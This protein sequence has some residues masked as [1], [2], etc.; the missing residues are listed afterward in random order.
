MSSMAE[1]GA[2][3]QARTG[4]ASWLRQAAIAVAVLA[5]AGCQSII[6][7]GQ[8]PTTEA[9][10]PPVEEEVVAGIPQ[11]ST[12]HRI[13]LLVP[14]SG[15]NAGVGQSIQ[16]ATTMALLD[17]QAENIRITAYDTA[18]GI[19]AA[20]NNAVQDGNKL[21][22]GPLL[23]DNVL[24]TANIAGRANIPMLSFSN[25]VSVARDNVFLLGHIPSQSIDRVVRYAES[26]GMQRFAALV[27]DNVYGQRALAAIRETTQATGARLVASQS[28]SRDSN[29]IDAA[30]KRL[31]KDGGDFDA[32]LIADSAELAIKAVPYV[33]RNGGTGKVLGTELWN[34]SG[35]LTG[36]PSMNGAWFASVSDGV[37]KQYADKYRARYGKA[38]FR[39]SSMGYDAV[40]LTVKIARDW[41]VGTPFPIQRLTDRDGFGGLDGVFRFMPNGVNER[42]LEV[43][44]VGRGSFTVIDPAPRGF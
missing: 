44:E 15:R 29:S 40:L 34:T 22:L 5:L 17:T 33:R 41:K 27:P 23:G 32:I 3:R 12:H 13:A 8:A 2:G 19:T 35:Q 9:P 4:A 42:A 37:Y 11:D 1:S 28:Y 26:K 24:A 38:P 18:A 20:A 6:P 7:E 16:N 36:A 39:L 30:T 21:I 25:D 10:P 14:L 31:V 43:Q